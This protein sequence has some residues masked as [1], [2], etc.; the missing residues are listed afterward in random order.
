MHGASSPWGPGPLLTGHPWKRTAYAHAAACTRPQERALELDTDAAWGPLGMAKASRQLERAFMSFHKGER[1]IS[2][3]ALMEQ[4]AV[5]ILHLEL[6]DPFHLSPHSWS[7]A[8]S[9]PAPTHTQPGLPRAWQPGFAEVPRLQEPKSS[10]STQKGSRTRR[11]GAMVPPDRP[12]DPHRILHWPG[13]VNL[14]P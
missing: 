11:R 2:I 8:R 13:H 10:P 7:V 4:L 12:G 6:H 1:E 3:L 14:G 9:K 5:S